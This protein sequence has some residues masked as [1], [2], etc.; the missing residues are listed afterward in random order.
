LAQGK[1]VVSCEMSS[2]LRKAVLQQDRWW[3]SRS[4]KTPPP[5]CSLQ[6]YAY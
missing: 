3:D 2:S 1:A 6:H 5:I 4:Q